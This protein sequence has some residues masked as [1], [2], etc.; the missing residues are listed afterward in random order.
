MSFITSPGVIVPPLT[1]GG[2][3]YGTGSQAMV[4]SAG[5]AGQFLQ[6]A[7][8][9]VPVFADAGSEVVRV[10]RTSNTVLVKVNNGN[11]IDITSGTFSQTFTAA[12]TLDDGWF[13]Y[14]R[15]NGTGVITLDPDSS[16]TIDGLTSYAMYTGE[17]RL[18]QCTG[19]AFF[20]VVLSPFFAKFTTSGTFVT[21]PGYTQLYLR[22]WGGG[23]G[24]SAGEGNTSGT[25]RNGGGGGGGGGQNFGNITAPA[26]GTS[27]T[28]TIGAGSA[29][30]SSG[31]NT[32]TGGTTTFTGYM[33]AFGGGG[34]SGGSSSAGIAGG[35]SLSAPDGSTG[36][37]PR[38]LILYREGGTVKQI[39]LIA[40]INMGGAG[41]NAMF[42]TDTSANSAASAGCSEHGGSG[43]GGGATGANDPIMCFGGKSLTGPTGGGQG[44][45]ISSGESVRTAGQ[46]GGVGYAINNSSGGYVAGSAMGGGAA[47]GVGAVGAAGSLLSSGSG[48]GGGG[49]GGNAAGAG[50]AGGAGSVPGGGGGGGGAG[51]VTGGAG[52]NGGNGQLNIIGIT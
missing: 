3:A 1:A 42:A 49:G 22:M 18:V 43:G 13:C 26:A 32:S 24:A 39:E 14:I 30:S 31:A 33:S 19:T 51:L 7:G 48:G 37:S 41:P 29:G 16:E 35:G 52:G 34:G 6:S 28:V 44:S 4:T 21:P 25:N 10:A 15:N 27:V 50:Y 46:G 23:C 17:V 45:G 38:P 5:T 8:A 9:G 20:S 47:G 40:G 11:L 12:A 36:G 2:V